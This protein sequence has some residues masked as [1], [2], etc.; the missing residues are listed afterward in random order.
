MKK[1]KTKFQVE[2][3]LVLIKRLTRKALALLE[4]P[5]VQGIYTSAAIHGV[6]LPTSYVKK[7]H[8]LF[9]ALKALVNA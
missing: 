9:K 7:A 2:Q 6:T 1:N 3:E 8:P 5:E 4:A